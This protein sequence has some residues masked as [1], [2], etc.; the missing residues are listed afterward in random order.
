MRG[1][2]TGRMV[3]ACAVLATI[4]AGTFAVVLVFISQLRET[5]ELRRDSRELLVAADTLEKHVLDLET[6]LR[7]FVITRDNSFLDPSN[8]A[9]AAL[10]GSARALE[11]LASDEPV[12]HARVQRIVRA[13]NAYLTDYAAPLVA[14]VRRNDP[15]A[16]SVERTFAAKQRVDA[17]RAGL[18]SLREAERV[19]L[20]GRDADLEAAARRATGA[21]AVGIAG[22]LLLVLV[23]AAYLARVIVRP[24]RRAAVMADQLAGGDLSARLPEND[25]GEIGALERSFNVMA[26]SLE[27]SRDELASLL[28]NQAALRRVA[29]LVAEAAAPAEVFTTVADE[30]G[31]LLDADTAVIARFDPDG[32]ATIAAWWGAGA[33]AMPVGSRW[34][35]EPSTLMSTVVR[36]GGAARVDGD[37]S[38]GDVPVMSAVAAPVLVGGRLWGATV[39][40]TRHLPLAS[41]AD[42]RMADFTELIATAIAN[43]DGRAELVASRARL[44]TAADD[45]RRRV[46]RDLHDGAQQR[47][48]TTIVA[49]KHADRALRDGDDSPEQL[50]TDA[51]EQAEAANTELRELA[52]GILPRVLVHGGLRHGVN[53]L[54]SRLQL[55]VTTDVQGERLPPEIEASAYFVIAESLTNVVKHADARGAEVKAWVEDGVLRIEIRD[56][57]V[58]GARRDGVGLQG[59]SDRITAMGG[60][61]DIDSPPGEGTLVSAALPL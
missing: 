16:N 60:R 26:G 55:P 25:I 52:H 27:Q 8:D 45:A 6:G 10:P 1:G 21:A 47:L 15:S 23:V 5:T 13:M 4:V 34:P 14:A 41:D 44:V 61:L 7:G 46:V 36:T 22:S 9:R 30:L 43:A 49:L 32:A 11:R 20:I 48:V 58:G 37:G 42:R 38:L 18:N 50:I 35:V 54:V 29:T 28:A 2:L 31:R 3:V 57:G 40:A 33:A 53:A 19:R 24:L 39:V 12:E 51:L 59:L 56:D 17:L